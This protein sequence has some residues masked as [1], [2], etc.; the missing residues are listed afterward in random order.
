M[1]CKSEAAR[2]SSSTAPAEINPLEAFDQEKGLPQFIPRDLIENLMLDVEC[3]AGEP[4]AKQFKMTRGQI[5]VAVPVF[6]HPPFEYGD[7]VI[8]VNDEVLEDKIHFYQILKELAGKKKPQI[9][10][11]AVARVIASV[12]VPKADKSIPKDMVS[13]QRCHY[14]KNTMIFF[15]RS[16]L[17]INIKSVNKKVYVESTDNGFNSIARRTFYIGDALLTVNDEKCTSV[18]KASKLLLNAL[19]TKGIARVIVERP[20]EPAA[21]AFVRAVLLVNKANVMDPKMSDDVL[22]ICNAELK[23]MR[24]QR[25]NPKKAILKTRGTETSQEIKTTESSKSGSK[26]KISETATE[27]AIGTEL[28]NPA[29]LEHVPEKKNVKGKK[30][31]DDV[32]D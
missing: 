23:R 7:Y 4:D 26:I 3:A 12:Q 1:A 14:F 19:K 13:T 15:P 5:L 27:V 11:F 30:K 22:T 8:S 17:G 9:I 24:Q 6:M 16:S 2:A 20:V 18:R 21:V 32:I 25:V 31:K 29:L 10:R 28:L